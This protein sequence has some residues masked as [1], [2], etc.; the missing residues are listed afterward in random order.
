MFANPSAL[1]ITPFRL[2]A[3]LGL[4]VSHGAAA[5]CPAPWSVITFDFG[6]A[7]LSRQHRQHLSYFIPSFRRGGSVIRIS[8]HADSTGDAR[9]NHR[10]ARRRAEAAG[11]YL[12]S[13]GVPRGSIDIVARGEERPMIQTL[14]GVEERRNR[15]VVIEELP[16]AAEIQRRGRSGAIC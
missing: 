15:Y 11:D 6:S 14:D 1:S 9:L 8:G 4:F 2:A 16:T 7:K 5:T 3:A 13:L 10:L 12:V